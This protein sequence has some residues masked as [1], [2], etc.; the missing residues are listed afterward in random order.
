LRSANEPALRRIIED[1]STRRTA[2]EAVDA[3]AAAGVPAAG[4]D[5]IAQALG[6][7]QAALRDPL[8]QMT[9]PVLGIIR[10]LEQP[11]RF[12]G[13]SRGGLAAAPTLGQH[14]AEI[15]AEIAAADSD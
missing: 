8:Q 2:A 9:H 12:A 4:I 7:E 3:L 13:A 10:T 15:R 1:W 14:S 5:T 11:V 6:S